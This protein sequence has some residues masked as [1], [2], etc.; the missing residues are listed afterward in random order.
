M[1]IADDHEMLQRGLKL[2]L[3]EEFRGAQFGESGNA[4]ETL[5]QVAAREWDLV[6]LDLN[7]PGGSG[8]DVLAEIKRRR[9]KTPVLI[10]SA[11]AESEYAVR[12]IRA[13]AAGFINKQYAAY[14]LIT[15]IRKVMSSG[16][17]VSAA[18]A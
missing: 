17:Y 4:R 2:I 16:T 7:M 13:G 15:A 6:L 8:L 5:E 1:L 10:L 11:S 12:T 9:P 18:V 3:L 14:E